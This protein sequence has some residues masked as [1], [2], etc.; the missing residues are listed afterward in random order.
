MYQKKIEKFLE[1]LNKNWRL[2]KLRKVLYIITKIL[3]N[4]REKKG[5]WED[6]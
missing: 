1:D 5:F 4:L 6:F 3:E 2:K